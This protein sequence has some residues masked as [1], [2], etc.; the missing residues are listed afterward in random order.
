MAGAH[1]LEKAGAED[2]ELVGSV[3]LPTRSS[4]NSFIADNVIR[5]ALLLML[6]DVMHQHV[7]TQRFHPRILHIQPH[8]CNTFKY[9]CICTHCI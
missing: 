9:T 7:H 2:D 8:T 6:C 5:Y 1:D 3:E 4:K